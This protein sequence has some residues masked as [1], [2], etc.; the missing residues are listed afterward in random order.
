MLNVPHVYIVVKHSDSYTRTNIMPKVSCT[1]SKAKRNLR[2]SSIKTRSSRRT[3]QTLSKGI[4]HQ[5]EPAIEDVDTGFN[6]SLHGQEACVEIAADLVKAMIGCSS[7]VAKHSGR[8]KISEKDV[9]LV[10]HIL[11]RRTGVL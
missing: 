6:M 5:S 3:R 1:K 4:G 9:S 7:A 2:S 11:L 10:Q 8:K